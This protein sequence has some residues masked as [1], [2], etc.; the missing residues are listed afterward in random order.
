MSGWT[1]SARV[2][3]APGEAWCIAADRVV[4]VCERDLAPTRAA[5]L[6][7]QAASV[8]SLEGLRAVIEQE[9]TALIALVDVDGA[10]LLL[11]RH[12]VP[13][14]ADA[15]PLADR[16]GAEWSLD[17]LGDGQRIAAGGLGALDGATLPLEGGVV[18]V[19]AVRVAPRPADASADDAQAAPVAD[20]PAPAAPSMGAFGQTLPPAAATEARAEAP[21]PEAFADPEAPAELA[22]PAEP[23]APAEPAAPAEP[24]APAEQPESAR[25]FVTDAGNPIGGL[26]DSVPGFIKPAVD[27]RAID[28]APQPPTES[29]TSPTA[30]P[31]AAPSAAPT[32]APITR[33]APSARPVTAEPPA[34]TSAAAAVPP[35]APA[36]SADAGLGDHD[37]MTV[38]ADR[39]RELRAERSQR[40]LATPPATGPLVLS[41]LCPEGHVNAPGTPQCSQCGAAIDEGSA[42]QRRRPEVAVAVLTSGE[43]VPLGRGVVIGRRPR[44]RRVEDGRVPR[45]VTVE[46]P[47]EDISRSHIELRMEDW[48]LVAIDLSST[49]GTL[50]LREGAAPQ[51]L[52]PEAS[53]ILQLGDRLDLGDAQ[54]VTI[55]PAP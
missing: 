13:A 43:R 5:E 30:A 4:L 32:A 52:R 24:E 46:S 12:G 22:A 8:A 29:T 25:P 26:I 34:P 20:T 45:L 48:N 50:L 3:Y 31:S 54:V 7:A 1:Q 14:A 21:E 40:E 6:H 38:T 23:E 47:G 28:S 9:L 55:E 33:P 44:S 27:V 53:T 42:A 39:A 41:T 35:A 15:S 51:R 49:N 16:F 10:R 18:R 17:E 37:G 2:E 11:R 36:A 19:A